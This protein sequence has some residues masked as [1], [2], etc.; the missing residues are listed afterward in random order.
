M[1]AGES[2]C[3]TSHT[4]YMFTSFWGLFFMW[5]DPQCVSVEMSV[6]VY[7]RHVSRWA[8]RFTLVQLSE[9]VRP[10]V[11][12][13][14]WFGDQHYELTAGVVGLWFSLSLHDCQFNVH[15]DFLYCHNKNIC[16]LPKHTQ[17]YNLEPIYLRQLNESWPSIFLS[18]SVHL[19][20]G[21]PFLHLPSRPHYCSGPQSTPDDL[22]I[23]TTHSVF[24]M[25]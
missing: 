15:M 18:V 9:S 3:V 10:A 21:R 17:K 11:A 23:Y 6:L 2:S 16:A 14:R 13:D 25:P 22:Y 20:I 7:R 19:S 24:L 5:W 8:S 12:T 4:L 1:A